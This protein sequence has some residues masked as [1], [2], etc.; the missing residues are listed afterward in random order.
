VH[1]LN[2]HWSDRLLAHT[3]MTFR[4][5]MRFLEDLV[6]GAHE[7]LEGMIVHLTTRLLNIF[8]M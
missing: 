8:A 6:Y 2:G 3:Y 7:S 5:F 4:Q 1:T